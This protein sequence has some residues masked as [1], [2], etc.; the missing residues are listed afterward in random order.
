MVGEPWFPV[1]IR[2]FFD[3]FVS[4]LL[5]SGDNKIFSYRRLNKLFTDN[6]FSVKETYKKGV[7]QIIMGEK[8]L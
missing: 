4:P 1:I 5:K 7:I 6:G 3:W 2:Q 8:L